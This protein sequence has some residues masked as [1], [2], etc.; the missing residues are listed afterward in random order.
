M[1]CGYYLAYVLT[2][3]DLRWMVATSFE[4][5]VMQ[6]WPALVMAALSVGHAE[7]RDSAGAAFAQGDT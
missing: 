6:L 3:L 5:L 2:T 7:M 1:L 4:R